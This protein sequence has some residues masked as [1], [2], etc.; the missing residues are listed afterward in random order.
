[1]RHCAFDTLINSLWTG[2]ALPH[3][4]S[5]R[6][7][8]PSQERPVAARADREAPMTG[9]VRLPF[10][11]RVLAGTEQHWYRSGDPN[12]K[13]TEGPL[14]VFYSHTV[15]DLDLIISHRTPPVADGLHG[16]D[17]HSPA[18]T[19][20]VPELGR[21]PSTLIAIGSGRNLRPGAPTPPCNLDQPLKISCCQQSACSHVTTNR[22][23]G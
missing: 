16:P 22:N 14:A 10:G 4:G 3:Q 5:P 12:P 17:S 20:S 9:A 7:P 1:M 2:C 15:H 11:H 21:S 18:S 23:C 6:P 19:M 13:L 8:K